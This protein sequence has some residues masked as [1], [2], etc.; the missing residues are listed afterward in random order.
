MLDAAETQRQVARAG[1]AQVEVLV[2]HHLR[3]HEHAAVL[4][5]VALGL[6][7]FPPEQRE[8]L[9]LDDDD[10]EAGPVAVGLFVGPYRE[11]GDVR[12]HGAVAHL[13]KDVLAAR[14]A[15]LPLLEVER[16]GVRD[17]VGLPDAAGML[18]ALAGEEVRPPVEAVHEVVGRVEDE[19]LVVEQAEDDGHV[20]DREQPRR[21]VAL[22]VEMLVMHVQRHRDEAPFL[23][24]EGLLG[25]VVVPDGGGAPALDHQDQLLVEVAHGVQALARRDLD[26]IGAGG[27]ARSLH[28]EEGAVAAH[29]GPPLERN[30]LQVLDEEG[31]DDV[32]PLAL[33]PLVEEGDVVH[34]GLD[35]L[36]RLGH[37]LLPIS[38][39]FKGYLL[40][41]ACRKYN[42]R[43]SSRPRRANPQSQTVLTYDNY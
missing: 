8:T 41:E 2:E 21:L 35:L 16:A 36:R 18:R 9:P 29:A 11:L 37:V 10:V 12:R 26:D 24:L 43:R 15:L 34:R 1:G 40:H 23:P 22:A 27:V 28:V 6:L 13:Q 38:M 30:L 3:R 5:V 39:K 19:L 32:N 17:E 25:A 14:A 4:P 20:V 7:A 42:N 31:L 33:L